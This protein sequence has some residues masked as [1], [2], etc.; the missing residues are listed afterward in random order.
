MK[1]A[2]LIK[3]GFRKLRRNKSRSVLTIL[4]LSIGAITLVL[5]LGVGNALQNTVDSQL[6]GITSLVLNVTLSVDTDENKT[7][8]SEYDPDAKVGFTRLDGPNRRSEIQLMTIEQ[9]EELADVFGV[10]RVWPSYDV[11]FEYI[12]LRDNEQKFIVNDIQEQSFSEV[13]TVSGVYP[14]EWEESTIVISESYVDSFGKSANELI[15]SEVTVGFYDANAELRKR[16]FTIVGIVDAT[17]SFGPPRGS[18]T[19]GIVTLSLESLASIYELQFKD[20]PDYNE[21]VSASVLIE[22]SDVEEQVRMDIVAVNDK[23]ELSSIS[24]ITETITSVLDTITLGLAGFSGIALLAAAFGIINT[25]L[26]SVFERKKEIGL[27]KALGMPNRNVRR[28]FSYEAIIIGLVGALIGS[29]IAFGAQ[30]LINKIFQEPLTDAGFINGIIN[31]SMADVLM[32]VA[33]LGL[34]SW[35]AGVIPARKAQKLDPIQALREE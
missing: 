7:G 23:Y 32:V 12:Q 1:R 13:E 10:I 5:T 29:A 18:D 22:S 28:L 4:A 20:T 25:Q 30:E 14:E 35:V 33:G 16:V 8:V 2:D 9:I 24:D 3:R 27:M 6:E 21:F 34:L 15:G 26:M 19:P 31:L 17:F 11:T